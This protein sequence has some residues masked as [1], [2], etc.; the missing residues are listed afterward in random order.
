LR[1][2]TSIRTL[3]SGVLRNGYAPFWNNGRWSNPPLD[4]NKLSDAL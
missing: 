1:L 3:R 2:M 4:C